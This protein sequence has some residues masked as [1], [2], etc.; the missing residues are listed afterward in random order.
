MSE[1]TML[2]DVL[3]LIMM[4][5]VTSVEVYSLNKFRKSNH[6]QQQI[7]IHPPPVVPSVHATT[8]FHIPN[9]NNYSSFAPDK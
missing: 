9:V 4:F 8:P 2:Y 5:I 3:M 7:Q 6:E 1:F